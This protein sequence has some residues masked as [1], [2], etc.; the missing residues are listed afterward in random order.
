MIKYFTIYGERCSGT[1]FLEGSIIYNFELEVTCKYG[2]KHFFGNYDFKNND[3]ENN[4]LFICIVRDP[5]EWINS[6]YTN[7]HHIPL[8]NSKDIN[9]FLFNEFYSIKNIN[10]NN[11][12]IE[13]RNFITKE[14][15]KNIFELRKTK[16]DFLIFTLPKLVKNYVII[17]YEDL[18]NNYD[19]V[20]N[21]IKLKF[22]LKMKNEIF[23]KNIKYYN[24]GKEYDKIYEKKD[25]I[26]DESIREIIINNLDITQEKLLNYI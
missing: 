22:D 19:N 17:K 11:E 3:E 23:L 10:I 26:F 2:W 6:L 13:D 8:E 7:K 12:I 1:N 14:R 15:Y 16:N 9:S 18:Y 4:T 20:L 5:V 21:Y 24:G 25:I